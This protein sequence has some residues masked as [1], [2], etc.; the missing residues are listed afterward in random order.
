MIRA[1]VQQLVGT[2][3]SNTNA[4]RPHP[5]QSFP[6]RGFCTHTGDPVCFNSPTDDGFHY[7]YSDLPDLS[8]SALSDSDKV[9]FRN[10]FSKYHDVFPFSANQLGRT[11]LVQHTIDTGDAMP[12][13]QKALSNNS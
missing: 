2:P 10:L 7:D 11:S 12:I 1:E 8:D 3:L 4:F 6:T 5:A 13:K 9:K